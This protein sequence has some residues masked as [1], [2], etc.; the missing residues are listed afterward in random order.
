M[1]TPQASC[2]CP[3]SLPNIMTVDVEDYFQ[4]T[5]FEDVVARADWGSF[6]SRVSANVDRMLEIFNEA[7]TR[8]TFFVLG[9]VAERFPELVRRIA[10]LG[11]EIGSHGYGHRLLYELDPKTFRQ[12]LRRAKAAVEDAVGVPVRGFRAPSFSITEQSLWSIDVLIDEGFRYDSSILPTRHRRGGMPGAPRHV[13]PIRRAGGTLWEVPPTTIRL[14]RAAVP[15]GGG[16][17]RLLP[18]AWTRFGIREVNRIEKQPAVI[19]VHPWELDPGQPR[20]EGRLQNRFRHYVNLHKTEA[21]LN[22]LVR[23]F[24]FA[25]MSAALA[26]PGVEP[27]PAAAVSSM[28]PARRLVAHETPR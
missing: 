26:R 12:D 23:D 8:A 20:I 15:L 21:R 27:L 9:W 16:Y 7:G 28:I 11:H 6:E 19:Y 18:Y 14:G 10:M 1:T 17:F 25:P 5:G 3:S 22:R 4:V 2:P 13:Y 24:A